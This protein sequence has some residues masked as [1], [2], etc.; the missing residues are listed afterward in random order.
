MSI[1]Q[2][3]SGFDGRISRKYFWL[4]ALVWMAAYIVVFIALL[5]WLSGGQWLDGE[6]ARTLEGQKVHSEAALIPYVAGLY[7]SLAMSIKRLHDLSLSGWWCL[8]AFAPGFIALLA[9][10]VGLSG[11][12][13]SPNLLDQLLLW[14]SSAVGLVYI[15]VLGFI[16]GTAGPNEYGPNPLAKTPAAATAS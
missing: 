10:L 16:R 6:Y 1:W 15:I 12:P 4:A 7:A 3:M 9:P 14:G 8:P 2:A 13:A 11:S 5:H